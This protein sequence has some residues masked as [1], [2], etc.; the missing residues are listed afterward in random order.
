MS[1]LLFGKFRVGDVV[2]IT[3]HKKTCLNSNQHVKILGLHPNY[4]EALGAV[5]VVENS[6]IS[7][8][9]HP[10]YWVLHDCCELVKPRYEEI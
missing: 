5:D 8:A 9:I 2:R 1:E 10:K 7:S 4:V 6:N 3:N